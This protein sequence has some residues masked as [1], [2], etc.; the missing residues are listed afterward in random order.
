MEESYRYTPSTLDRLAA[1]RVDWRDVEWV[2]RYQRPVIRERIGVSLLRIIGQCQHFGPPWLMV[3]LRETEDDIYF[4]ESARYLSAQ[5]TEAA[6][7]TLGGQ[8]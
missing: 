7:R 4:I 2:L 5:E 1:N 3:I 6:Q 8:L